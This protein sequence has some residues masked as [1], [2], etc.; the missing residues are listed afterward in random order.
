MQHFLEHRIKNW[1]DELFL[2]TKRFLEEKLMEKGFWELLLNFN[3]PEIISLKK[4]N[5]SKIQNRPHLQ[6]VRSYFENMQ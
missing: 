3:L 5:I 4:L 2:P 6:F 1:F